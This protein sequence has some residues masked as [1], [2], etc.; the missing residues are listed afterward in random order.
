MTL[1]IEMEDILC[2][3]SIKTAELLQIDEAE[4]EYTNSGEIANC[5]PKTVDA[6]LSAQP[7]AFW[8]NLEPSPEFQDI[9]DVLLSTGAEIKVVTKP[10]NI[11]SSQEGKQAWINTHFPE[12]QLVFT[13]SKH[14]FASKATTLIDCKPGA[15][16]AFKRFGGGGVIIPKSW[17]KN[18]KPRENLKQYLTE[19]I[20]LNVNN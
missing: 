8:K 12:A 13:K 10:Y 3:V 18:F 2:N 6:V 1:L 4:L 14:V 17:Q 19:A 5:D 9:K 11:S 7:V 16:Q 20:G 15:I